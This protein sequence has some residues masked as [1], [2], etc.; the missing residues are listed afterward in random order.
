MNSPWR[1]F[2]LIRFPMF[3]VPVGAFIV[4]MIESRHAWPNGSHDALAILGVIFI[5]AGTFAY[6]GYEDR[7]I[8]ARKGEAFAKQHPL[9]SLTVALTTFAIGVLLSVLV[10]LA[11]FLALSAFTLAAL[12]YSRFGVKLLAVKNLTAAFLSA[13]LIVLGGI[14]AGAVT[15]RHWVSFAMAFFGVTAM[16]I[17]N[18]VEDREADRGFRITLS[19]MLPPSVIKGI[20][21]L[22]VVGALF[23]GL[24]LAIASVWFAI[25]YAISAAT[26]LASVFA[27][28]DDRSSS[29]RLP[30]RF[31]YFGLWFGVAA[32]LVAA[33]G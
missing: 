11:T 26:F 23:F 29:V 30:K 12:A 5:A 17:I 22:L 1:Y 33:M 4:G 25:F 8:D 6:N 10:D 19:M 16:E 18:D 13:I 9:R 14:S 7:E 3:F 31:L 2:R 27:L 32:L 28:P 21:L 15:A 20:T 24:Q